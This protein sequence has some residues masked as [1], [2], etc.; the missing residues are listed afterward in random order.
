MSE[1]IFNAEKVEELFVKYP[2]L[3]TIICAGTVSLKA[4]RD[5][6]KIDRYE[7]YNLY[8]EMLECGAVYGSGSNMYRASPM[9][10]EYLNKE[11]E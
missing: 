2:K 10:R 5:I 11:S 4:T 9:L 6:L 3:R 8:L 7:G 1:D